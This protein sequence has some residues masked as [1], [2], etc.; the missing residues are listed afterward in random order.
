VYEG[1]VY[2]EC[3]MEG[4][5]RSVCGRGVRGVYEVYIHTQYLVASAPVGVIDM[6]GWVESNGLRVTGDRFG[7]AVSLERWSIVKNEW[8]VEI[9]NEQR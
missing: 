7:S 3:M 9:A 8:M 4:C 5:T 6:V 1:G 2:E